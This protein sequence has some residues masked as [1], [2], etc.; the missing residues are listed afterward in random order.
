MGVSTPFDG[1]ESSDPDNDPLTYTW[2][3]GDQQ[4]GSGPT[5]THAYISIGTYQA[6]MTVSDGQEQ[7]IDEL[8]VSV[9]KEAPSNGVPDQPE[10]RP[11][12]TNQTPAETRLDNRQ[13]GDMLINELL[14]NPNGADQAGEFIELYNRGTKPIALDNWT[15]TD[16]TKTFTISALTIDG[17]DYLALPY[18]MTRMLLRNGGGAI[19][20]IDPFHA[21]KSTVAYPSAKDGQAYARVAF[22]EQWQW[23]DLP[24]PGAEN[25][26]QNADV[27]TSAD[28]NDASTPTAAKNTKTATQD[29]APRDIISTDIDDLPARTAVRLSGSVIVPPGAFSST[30][31]WLADSDGSVE[32][33]FSGRSI[34]KLSIN[35]SVAVLGNTS[36]AGIGRRVNLAADGLGVKGS[37]EAVEPEER[38]LGS[39]TQD[40]IGRLVV[41]EG[42]V[43]AV[44]SRTLTLSDDAG[45]SMT[46]SIKR[47]TGI[48][49]TKVK[50]DAGIQIAGINRLV[51]RRAPALA[52]PAKRPNDSG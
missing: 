25:E 44:T 47:G 36:S 28:P 43:Q 15:L 18:A 16:D 4:S 31:F 20:L 21:T 22:G 37:T 49:L 2:D 34:P 41:V 14:P 6:T 23:T 10:Q 9:E 39:L 7:A 11:T 40:D 48:A 46:V 1:T 38:E 35:D 13:T 50:K 51:R 45:D 52:A 26:I 8:T 19:K 3:F 27:G 29:E 30:T 5:P 33:A 24:T 32:I 12:N 42:A 17:R